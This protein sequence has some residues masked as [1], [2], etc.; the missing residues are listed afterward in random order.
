MNGQIGM[1]TL[2]SKK[3]RGTSSCTGSVVVSKFCQGKECIPIV[4]LIIA[5]DT[6][7]LLERLISV[8]G[9]TITFRVISRSEVKSHV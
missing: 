3:G 6:K 1:V 4:L 5:E 2:V 8:F 9:L 7:V